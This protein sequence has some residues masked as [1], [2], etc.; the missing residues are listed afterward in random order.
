MLRLLIPQVKSY[1]LRVPDRASRGHLP[2]CRERNPNVGF[3]HKMNNTLL[4]ENEEYVAGYRS[5]YEDGYASGFESYSTRISYA[6]SGSK[7]YKE[8]Y[9]AGYGAGYKEGSKIKEE[10]KE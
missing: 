10:A 1:V 5:G 3:H 8:G 4:Y 6:S 2:M 7:V 9:D